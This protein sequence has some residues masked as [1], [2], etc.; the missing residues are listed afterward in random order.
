MNCE[1]FRGRIPVICTPQRVDVTVTTAP[2]GAA[3]IVDVNECSAPTTCTTMF[4]T[5]AN[6]PQIAAAALSGSSTTF[7]DTSV[8]LGNY[9]GFDIDQVGST[10]S[11]SNLTVTLV[12][13]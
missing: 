5:Q 7:D 9:I 8:A 4:T 2:T 13:Q 1:N 6:R 10:V 12:C 3:L 11:G